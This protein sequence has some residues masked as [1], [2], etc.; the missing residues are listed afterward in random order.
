MPAGPYPQLYSSFAG[1]GTLATDAIGP[2]PGGLLVAV[3][4]E[5]LQNGCRE[6]GFL[7]GDAR[8]KQLGLIPSAME[9]EAGAP[10]STI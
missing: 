2:I 6:G 1:N 10:R 3:M 7:Q 8:K 9:R 5:Q 4:T